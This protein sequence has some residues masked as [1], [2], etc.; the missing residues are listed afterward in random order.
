MSVTMN[1]RV[2]SEFDLTGYTGIKG[3]VYGLGNLTWSS[4]VKT[5]TISDN[6]GL[7][8]TGSEVVIDADKR[9]AQQGV[10]PTV[11]R[12]RV[13]D[14]SSR[15]YKSVT[16]RLYPDGM[17]CWAA[18][19]ANVLTYTGWGEKVVSVGSV[20]TTD[21]VL[22]LFRNNNRIN[23]GQDWSPWHL[24]CNGGDSTHA[25]NW[26]FT[27]ILGELGTSVVNANVRGGTYYTGVNVA[28]YVQ[29]VKIDEK[30]AGSGISLMNRVEKTLAA[31]GG[32][33][34][35]VLFEKEGVLDGGGHEITVYGL[36]VDKT[37][38][39][40]DKNYYRGVFISDSDD[41]IA[42]TSLDAPNRIRYV[43]LAWSSKYQAYTFENYVKPVAVVTEATLLSAY[44]ENAGT[45]Q[46]V[47]IL[48]R[49]PDDT[50]WW[51]PKNYPRRYIVSADG[52]TEQPVERI[53][54][55]ETYTAVTGE[56]WEDTEI[57]GTLNLVK[58]SIAVNPFVGDGGTLTVARGG[59]LGGGVWIAG[60][61]DL[62]G[63][64]YVEKSSIQSGETPAVDFLL[65]GNAP[66]RDAAYL[67][68]YKYLTG[69]FDVQV[70]IDNA[71]ETGVYR[72]A[73]G[74]TGFNTVVEL[75]MVDASGEDGDAESGEYRGI[76]WLSIGSELRADGRRYW[77]QLDR[78]GNL[79]FSIETADSDG[80]THQNLTVS[81]AYA[82]F[83]ADTV[84]VNTRLTDNADLYVA[85]GAT[86]VG[87]T[88]A[89]RSAL[90]LAG[91]ARGGISID[92]NSFLVLDEGASPE[93]ALAVS[94]WVEVD[95]PVT[96][97]RAVFQVSMSRRKM[98]DGPI[99]EGIDNLTGAQYLLQWDGRAANGSVYFASGAV[100]DDFCV[101]VGDSARTLWV[102]HTL[103]F[104]KKVY[105]LQ[106]DGDTVMFSIAGSGGKMPGAPKISPEQ[107]EDCVSAEIDWG[108]T[109]VRNEYRINDGTWKLYVGEVTAEA[110][111]AVFARG[112]NASGSVI[113]GR[114]KAFFGG[115]GTVV[116]DGTP[117]PGNLDSGDRGGSYRS[118]MR[119]TERC[120]AS[121]ALSA[122]TYKHTV[123]ETADGSLKM[124][125]GGSVAGRIAGFAKVELSGVTVGGD[126]LSTGA[127]DIGLWTG[128]ETESDLEILLPAELSS[129]ASA[130]NYSRTEQ[131]EISFDGATRVAKL[132]WTE[133]SRSAGSAN[134]RNTA[135]AGVIE[136]F[137]KV[138]IENTA[139][140]QLAV[141]AISGGDVYYDYAQE[142]HSENG[143][144]ATHAYA[145]TATLKTAGTLRAS[146]VRIDGTVSGFDRVTLEDA[147][148]DTV[149]GFRKTMAAS[150]GVITQKW[151]AAA[152][153]EFAHCQIDM[154]GGFS[155]LKV[156]DSV[157]R[158]V[159]GGAWV[160]AND[161]WTATAGGTLRLDGN[162][163]VG[164]V[165]DVAAIKIT[166]AT[167]RI[168]GTVTGV[169]SVSVGAGERLELSTEALTALTALGK[170]FSCH[171]S[172]ARYDLGAAEIAAAFTT[173]TRELTDNTLDSESILSGGVRGWLGNRAES[174]LAR[175]YLDTVDF[176]RLDAAENDLSGWQITGAD[177]SLEVRVFVRKDGAWDAG[178]V[179][180][181][182]NGV[183]NL[184]ATDLSD[185]E[186]YRIGVSIAPDSPLG[187][188]G[189][190]VESRLA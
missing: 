161:A 171:S 51:M 57:Y 83:A 160:Y 97:D 121:G 105:S 142:I 130:G 69:D 21:Y 66:D 76:G 126:V 12:I 73:T 67:K 29:N 75:G 38:K 44:D 64:T 181:G 2:K 175:T 48:N 77:L 81:G 120:D 1:P 137:H 115:G 14:S 31:A 162:A 8:Y 45:P 15:R 34:L 100:T 165:D 143:T 146:S 70:S 129:S 127:G 166:G 16:A 163:V 43:E 108:S 177:R 33:C 102:N 158:Q 9:A 49:E 19:A 178:T 4:F 47:S 55:G 37:K 88:V 95:G 152:T 92:R 58:N 74:A 155:T 96:A 32:V 107:F 71:Q 28:K 144:V 186:T 99:F 86:V 183:W 106:S 84:S 5:T 18:A 145:L 41:D 11:L 17:L 98:A 25:M 93:G 114:Q 30:I 89:D 87:V 7:F 122:Y 131:A 133:R 104:G 36:A 123:K 188:Y 182:E 103:Q 180:A 128:L 10:D 101:I 54:A 132:G 173:G 35:A 159:I 40:S 60:T 139:G 125:A 26:F 79:S 53:A 168:F 119:S 24:T 157:V 187:I 135:V 62:R 23:Y 148:A 85:D 147:Q 151:T 42:A 190:G 136:G 65:F 154:A 113:F 150:D 118:D 153:G 68:N 138:T 56:W 91:T 22:N 63:K 110:D 179:I 172:V 174:E 134:L 50:V 3:V 46:V 184:S 94:G 167:N 149:D 27:G 82:S 111:D 141:G 6:V 185:S 20:N 164:A 169:K 109:S 116:S 13:R 170:K 117:V 80:P 61:L 90:Y 52:A 156:S 176:F 78:K 39:T 112:T 189:Y 124:P 72:L 59:W 140:T